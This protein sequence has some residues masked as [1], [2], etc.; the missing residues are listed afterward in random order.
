MEA[1][2]RMKMLY[3]FTILDPGYVNNVGLLNQSWK[4]R[5]NRIYIY[6][7]R[8]MFRTTVRQTNQDVTRR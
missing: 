5:K 4:F 1:H 8:V 2:Y 6:L 7:P 3:I